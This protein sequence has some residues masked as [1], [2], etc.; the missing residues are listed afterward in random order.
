MTTLKK[1]EQKVY[2]G[3]AAMERATVHPI[4]RKKADAVMFYTIEEDGVVMGTSLGSGKKAKRSR[5]I[6]FFMRNEFVDYIEPLKEGDYAKILGFDH[7]RRAAGRHFFEDGEI[8]RLKT[9]T[10]GYEGFKAEHL[11]K[12][13]WWNVHINDLVA[14]TEEEVEAFELAEKRKKLKVGDI[15]K[16]IS[17]EAS[18][19]A[20][21]CGRHGIEI[22][23]IVK[24]AAKS[25][26]K[27]D[28]YRTELLSGVTPHAPYVHV[29]D[30][31]PAT[32][33]E[34]LAAQQELLKVG[35]FVRVL[36]DDN[37]FAKKDEI[38]KIT[39]DDGDSVP[40]KLERLNGEYAGYQ[41][42]SGVAP[43]TEA[44]I[45]A[46]KGAL[47]AKSLKAQQAALQV[48]DIVKVLENGSHGF[49]EGDVL[50]IYDI[51]N[52][53]H[54][55]IRCERLDG[56]RIRKDYFYNRELA[57][58]TGEE[59][60]AVEAAVEA[61]E[62]LK[63]GEFAKVLAGGMWHPL[64]TG[65][66]VEVIRDEHD[67]QPFYSKRLTDGKTAYFEVKQLQRATDEEVTKVKEEIERKKKE[68][69]AEALKAQQAAL[70]AGE[71]AR[72]IGNTCN[73]DFPIGEI[74]VLTR[75]HA[76]GFK[77]DYLDG[78]D[79]W[80]MKRADLA[81]ATEEEVKEAKRKIE[82]EKAKKAERKKFEDIGREVGEIKAGDVVRYAG[83][84]EVVN[85]VKPTHRKS[86]GEEFLSHEKGLTLGEREYWAYIEEVEL[87]TPVENRFDARG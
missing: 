26:P 39:E 70:K 32:K 82:E 22:G 57:L 85:E 63:E 47:E 49:E 58:A 55:R 8:V 4:I 84:L 72:V 73:H 20:D 74:I 38:V 42:K 13:D 46:A 34:L 10:T 24:L 62:R 18:A 21:G 48:G 6:N 27:Y 45:A 61:K 83:K 37:G 1:A 67:H 30:V 87:V 33:E 44:E 17:S 78:H 2:T 51:V 3:I 81:P 15:V 25:R 69:E 56:S 80:F 43:A 5:D 54:N 31:V 86:T 40:F 12:R 16:V 28:G 65:D 19:N 9:P 71:Y 59:E 23:T 53:G 7:T 35:D 11:D 52:Y 77:A 79:F 29:N 50:R 75:T 36:T 76:D 64:N 66:I 68:A 41:T 14:A 60:A